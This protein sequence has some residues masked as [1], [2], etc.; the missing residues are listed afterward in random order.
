MEFVITKFDLSFNIFYLIGINICLIKFYP[1]SLFPSLANQI[2]SNYF[3]V[4]INAFNKY[5]FI[6]FRLQHMVLL[7]LTCMLVTK[8]LE[9]TLMASS[10]VAPL[11]LSTTLFLFLVTELMKM[12]LIT[13]WSKTPGA[14]IGAMTEPSR[15][16]VE[17][18][19]VALEATAIQPSVKGQVELP[20][21]LQSFLH[22][23]KRSV[24]FLKTILT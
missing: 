10:Q 7:F 2:D 23:T 4:K 8:L 19:S 5:E 12:E 14:P 1:L 22:R 3:W 6:F 24:I 15:S 13:G 16:S 21:I 9:T 11:R 20:L 17:P 18:T